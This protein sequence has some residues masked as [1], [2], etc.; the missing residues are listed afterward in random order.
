MW[1][2]YVRVPTLQSALLCLTR[3]CGGG[4]C[5]GT[6]RPHKGPPTQ[7]PPGPPRAP[8]GTQA[9]SKNPL[10]WSTLNPPVIL[11]WSFHD[12]WWSLRNP[13]MILPWSSHDP[14]MI[15]TLH[16]QESTVHCSAL[17]TSAAALTRKLCLLFQTNSF[18]PSQQSPKTITGNSMV[19]RIHWSFLG[20]VGY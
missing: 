1:P 10:P 11:S 2:L 13:P 6:Q 3:P 15:R 17:C 4:G 20:Y 9:P 14:P 19:I 18:L 7:G 12:P 8:K 5:K 16:T